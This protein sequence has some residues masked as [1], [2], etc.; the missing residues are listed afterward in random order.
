MLPAALRRLIQ[1]SV[2]LLL[3]ALG[4]A[5]RGSVEPIYAQEPSPTYDPTQVPVP[6]GPPAALFGASSYQQNCAPCHGAQGMGDGPTAADLPGPATA[7][8]DPAAIWELSPSQLFHTTKFGRIQNLMPPWG[9]ELTDE[10]IWQTVAYAWSLHT[11]ARET[12][13]GA[14]LYSASCASCHGDQGAGDGPEAAVDLLDLGDLEYAINHS[15]AAWLAGWQS[16]HPELGADWS[17]AQ[18]AAVLE[19]IRTFS[20]TPP[21]NDAYR[22]GN[23]VIQGSVVQGTAGGDPVAGLTVTLEAYAGF[24][25]LKVF[26]ATVDASGVYTFPNLATDATINYL[27]STNAAGIRYTSSIL[28]FPADGS[29]LGSQITIYATTD[30][31][32]VLRMN[33]IHWIV[34]P[35]PGAVIVVEVYGVGAEGDRT[36]VGNAIEGVAQPATVAIPVPAAAED[37]G[38]ENGLLGERFQQV[39]DV[40]YDTA[41]VLPGEGSRQIIMR[42]L[43]P[44]ADRSLEL[45]RQFAYPVQDMSLL[46]AELPSLEVEIPGFALASQETFQG[47]NYQLWRA[48]GAIPEELTIRLNGLLAADDADPRA[49]PGAVDGATATTATAAI[50]LADWLPW[51]VVALILVGM[52]GV[53]LWAAR[54]GRLGGAAQPVDPAKQRAALLRR[55]AELDDQHA[56]G[57][58]GEQAWQQQRARLKAQLLSSTTENQ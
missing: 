48:E 53:V 2:V 14:E 37:L 58:L 52:V 29:E 49:V 39:G 35:R 57:Q 15:Q 28:N 11:T 43:V 25:P 21:W 23:G 7:F 56:L 6:A 22:P 31:P 10:E 4:L 42:Y 30:D 8:A 26:T 24:T 1:F 33:R 51:T 54:S 44:L 32:A 40:A 16:A 27:A 41:P 13:S 47:Q 3:L 55:I 34:D 20:Y 19:Y 18:Q 46:I 5:L 17:E 12:A 38:F 36:Y 9:N 45:T 50:P